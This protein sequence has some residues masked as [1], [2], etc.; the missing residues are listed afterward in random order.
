M[1]SSEEEPAILPTIFM[2]AYL[3]KC[4]PFEFYDL[5]FE[6]LEHTARE[7]DR[8]LKAIRRSSRGD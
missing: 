3:F 7:A 4:S 5:T 6:E 2:L 1:I 8:T